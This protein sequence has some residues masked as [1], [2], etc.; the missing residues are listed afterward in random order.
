M[1]MRILYEMSEY[2]LTSARY[3]TRKLKKSKGP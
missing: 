3:M 1:T 2:S